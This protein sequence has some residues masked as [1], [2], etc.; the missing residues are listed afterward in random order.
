MRSDGRNRDELRKIE[1]I[2]DFTH[3][4]GGSVLIKCGNTHVLCTAMLDNKTMPFK[5]GTGE[6]WLTAE[7]AM[8]PSSTITRKQR[9]GGKPDGRSTEIKRLIGRSLRE[10]IDYKKLGERTIWIDCDVLQAD[11]GTRTASI[12]GGYVA[13]RLG[14]EKW[15]K[16]GLLEEDP[17]VRQI[18]AVSV[19]I[20]NGEPILDLCY[21]ED[22]HAD[23]DMN[24]ISTDEGKFVEIQGTGEG[25][26]F[27][28]AELNELLSLA[29]KGNAELR[30]AQLE[31]LKR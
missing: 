29:E 22:S 12:T 15:L 31:A 6:G 23:V 26:S 21:V 1:I 25:R 7:Y 13:L 20:V 4:S 14:V 5:E 9:E 16:E 2:P 27:S 30:A 18:S 17:V 3:T 10:A 11:G 24:V 28:S 19:G 8:L